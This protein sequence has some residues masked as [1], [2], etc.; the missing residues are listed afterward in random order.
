MRL[1]ILDKDGTIVRPKSGQTF[2]QSPEDQELIPGVTD[3]IAKLV[4]EGFTLAISSNQGGVAAGHK[5]LDNAIR[6]MRYCLNL[7]EMDIQALFCPD[8][9]GEKCFDVRQD[10]FEIV[11]VDRRRHR[12]VRELSGT[13]RKPG[14]GMVRYLLWYWGDDGLLPPK[15]CLFIGD[16]EEDAKCAAGAGIRFLNAVEWWGG[17]A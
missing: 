13:F 2:V 14:S 12:F 4:A 1:C 10:N 5:S 11:H 16:R 17:A 15:D 8:F 7:L 3:A 6:E 9:E